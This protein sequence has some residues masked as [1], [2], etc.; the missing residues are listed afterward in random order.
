M[1]T[2]IASPVNF[3]STPKNRSG[4]PTCRVVS[5][6]ASEICMRVH[7]CARRHTAALRFGLACLDGLVDQTVF[8]TAAEKHQHKHTRAHTHMH[9]HMHKHTYT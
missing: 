8:N 9:M 4:C 3:S 5:R 1:L 7:M 2:M 6:H